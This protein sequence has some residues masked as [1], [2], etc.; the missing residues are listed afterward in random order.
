[1]KKK[2]PALLL[3]LLLP[4]LLGG[5]SLDFSELADDGALSY[6]YGSRSAFVTE[7]RWDGTEAG[8]TVRIPAQWN[9]KKI[10]SVGG[11]FGRGLPMPFTVDVSAHF[12]QDVLFA[13]GV[14]PENAEETAALDFTLLLPAGL[15]AEDVKAE[16]SSWVA[17][18][19]G[20]A[21]AYAV[22]I[23]VLCAD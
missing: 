5:C 9:G 1:M 17:W 20:R 21:V 22:G 10:V 15:S 4:L 19:D 2:L 11:Y 8:R 7:Y 3:C 14:S 13:D 23:T 18:E 6:A 16:P 12:P